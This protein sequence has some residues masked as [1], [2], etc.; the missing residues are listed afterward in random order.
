MPNLNL[1]RAMRLSCSFLLFFFAC[2]IS[3]A[4][5]NPCNTDIQNFDYK[6]APKDTT[7][8]LPSG[9]EL[10]FNR[11][12]FFD[13]RDCIEYHEIRTLEDALE[14]DLTTQDS[15]GNPL[16][17]GGMLVISFKSNECGKECLEV[18]ARVRIPLLKN[19]CMSDRDPFMLYR[20]SLANGWVLSNEP[21]RE[22]EIA[23]KK[24]LEFYTKCGGRFNADKG[25]PGI[26]V[27]FKARHGS[28][29]TSINLSSPCPVMNMKFGT[30]KRRNIIHGKVFCINPDS[31]IVKAEG[32]DKDG[33]AF[34]QTKPLSA[35]TVRYKRTKCDPI[36]KRTMRSFLGLFPVKERNIYRKY[37]VN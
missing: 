21:A 18:P 16:L 33:K 35:F 14:N 36:S 6:S 10:T 24:Y 27:K 5:K 26:K 17:T 25:K 12:E 28:E 32:I 15:S 9:T 3:F 1:Y 23:G 2:N 19:A 34:S 7:I 8:I 31:I 4:Q 11:C 20:M 29:L 22:V 37:L 30:K 13:I